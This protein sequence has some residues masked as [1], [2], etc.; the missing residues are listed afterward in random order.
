MIIRYSLLVSFLLLAFSGKAQRYFF[1]N[2]GVQQGLPASKVYAIVED[3][4]GKIWIGDEA[5]ISRYNG[6]SVTSFG[7]TEGVSQNGVRAL[8][9]DTQGRIW[10]GHLGGGLTVVQGNTFHKIALSGTDIESDI[11]GITEDA[12]GAIWVCTFGQGAFRF[13]KTSDLSGIEAETFSAND[14]IPNKLTSILRLKN[15]TICFT[16]ASGSISSYN[17]GKKKFEPFPV[18]G[19][20]NGQRVT[21]IFEDSQESLWIGTNFGGVFQYDPQNNTTMTYDIANGLPSNFVFSIA[22]GEKGNIWIGTWDGGIARIEESGVRIF[23]PNNGLHGN[24][25]R[26]MVRDHEGNMLIGTNENGLDI[27]KGER[28]ISFNEADGL[29]EPQVW[30]IMEDDQ[31]RLWLGTNGGIS[32]LD[33]TG[34]STARVKNLTMQQGDL[35]SNEVRDLVQDRRGN[36]WIGTENGGLFEFDPRTFKF[37]YDLEISGNIPGNQVTALALGEG[38]EL[39][40]GTVNGLI[41]Y[42]PGTIPITINTND[43]LAGGQVTS[44]YRDPQGI[45]WVGS[46][47]KGITR[48]ENGTAKA[49]VIDRS[50][51]ATCFIQDKEGRLWVGTEG[52]GVLVLK[53]GVLKAEYT[54]ERG[55]LSNSIR[56]LNI[57]NEGHVWIGSNRG[58]NKWRPKADGFISYTERAGFTGIEAKPNSTYLARDGSLWFGTANGATKVASVKALDKLPPPITT[59]DGL[60]VNLEKHALEEDPSLDHTQRSIRFDYSSVSLTD[61]AAVMYQYRLDG[62][63]DDWQPPTSETSI[64][65]PALPPG[66]YTFQVKAMNRSGTWSDPP[67]EYPFTILPPWYK[68]WWFYS[69]VALVLAIGLFSYIKVRERQLKQRNAILEQRVTERTA[70]VVAQSKEIDGQKVRIEELLLNILPK[71]ISEELKEKGK[72]T[73]RRHEHVSVMFTDMKGFTKAAENM[74]P[75]Q[76]VNELDECFI[77]FDAIVGRYGIEKIKTIGDSYMCACGVPVADEHHAWKSALAALEVRTLMAK[78]RTERESK[79]LVPWL[80]RIGIHSG[81]LV[82]GVVGKRKFAYDIWGDTVNT[83]S[84]MES[85]GE[86]GEVNISETTYHLIKDRFECDHRGAIEA[87]NKGKIDMYFVRRIKPEYSVNGSGSEPNDRFLEEMGL[88]VE[89]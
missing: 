39:W 31:G 24:A 3:R 83:A 85:S 8:Y 14:G 5:G 22:E 59:I 35:T 67:A 86:I 48:I 43:G 89:A 54:T 29:I 82:A 58:L 19:L 9:M 80:L 60:Q 25:I 71:E 28:F 70:E 40:V 79:G 1:E 15:G 18:K 12:S 13:P 36:V 47:L 55:L 77:Q 46:V 65:Y 10:A 74:T 66:S 4:A 61:P 68:S 62:L 17:S 64:H 73:A 2:V 44:I 21:T 81:P 52:Q 26:C 23:N 32:I 41:R 88:L 51:T 63:E 33:P 20:P 45:F 38:N 42:T 11:T 27:F 37:R 30:A 87:K 34:K 75:E 7:T 6:N 53:D 16:D 69:L 84:R 72:A 78:W 49:V 76:L 50:F 56:S 57:D